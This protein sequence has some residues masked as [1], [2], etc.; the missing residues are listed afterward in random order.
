MKKIYNGENFDITVVIDLQDV[1]IPA[2][3]YT[4]VVIPEN[5]TFNSDSFYVQEEGNFY[6]KYENCHSGADIEIYTN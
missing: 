1:V 2:K 5:V 6:A 3:S 4:E